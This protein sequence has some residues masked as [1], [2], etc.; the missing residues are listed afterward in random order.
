MRT[1]T[2]RGFSCGVVPP[3]RSALIAMIVRIG[4]HHGCSRETVRSEELRAPERV[5]RLLARGF[6]SF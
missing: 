6:R 2:H 4:A 5:G 1:Y 3:V